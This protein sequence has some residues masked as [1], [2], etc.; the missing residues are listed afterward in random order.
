MRVSSDFIGL[1]V[2]AIVAVTYLLVF[3]SHR[4]SV[5]ALQTPWT[6]NQPYLQ[7]SFS[8]FLGEVNNET[9]LA[10]PTDLVCNISYQP[11]HPRFSFA[12]Y[13]MSAACRCMYTLQNKPRENNRDLFYC[14]LGKTSTTEK[15]VYDRNTS[16]WTSNPFVLVA[17]WNTVA[18]LAHIYY[19]L[20]LKQLRKK[21]PDE[22]LHEKEPDAEWDIVSLLVS[23]ITPWTPFGFEWLPFV[24][25]LGGVG[26]IVA[27]AAHIPDAIT[28]QQIIIIFTF[29]LACIYVRLKSRSEPVSR[30]WIFWFLYATAVVIA[31]V[32]WN[33]RQQHRDVLYMWVSTLAALAFTGTTVACNLFTATWDEFKRYKSDIVIRNVHV[34]NYAPS[35]ISQPDIVIQ[36]VHVRNFVKMSIFIPSN[37]AE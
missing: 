4:H 9:V 22:T 30:A 33:L 27:A 24:A 25:T 6:Y 26:S 18:L 1:A 35:H 12:P 16:Y 3:A 36:N 28:S 7:N 17:T 21:V 34:R 15:F 23:M 2:C 37:Y 20:P 10:L 14:L 19:I 31:L 29:R 32:L 5:P 8:D 13:N 11:I